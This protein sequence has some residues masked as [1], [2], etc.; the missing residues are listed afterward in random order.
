MLVNENRVLRKLGDLS[1]PIYLTHVLVAS[2][3]PRIFNWLSLSGKANWL[4]IL[5]F[6]V[7]LS[8]LLLGVTTPIERLRTKIRTASS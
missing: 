7:L 8:S 2:Q 1:Y 3:L 5:I 4:L 6:T